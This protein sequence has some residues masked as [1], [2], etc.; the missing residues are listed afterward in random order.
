MRCVT[1][2][3][4]RPPEL[5]IVFCILVADRVFASSLGYVNRPLSLTCVGASAICSPR[6]LLPSTSFVPLPPPFHFRRTQLIEPTLQP[7]WSLNLAPSLGPILV[8]FV[9]GF[10]NQNVG[11]G[12]TY[13]VEITWIF[14]KLVLLLLVSILFL[15]ACTARSAK[16]PPRVLSLYQG[17]QSLLP[18][19]GLSL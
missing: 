17:E 7:D 5:H 3:T 11:W 12:R 1:G 4:S 9:G 2:A 10:I 16:F 8:L 18:C 6:R 15:F 19:P 14:I 13:W